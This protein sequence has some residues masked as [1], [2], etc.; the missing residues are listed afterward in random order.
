M[1]LNVSMVHAVAAAAVVQ[2]ERNAENMAEVAQ[3][4]MEQCA[5]RGTQQPR[6]KPARSKRCESGTVSE[7]N[8]WHNCGSRDTVL[9]RWLPAALR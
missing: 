7:A 4:Y 2:V 9:A 8:R 6:P 3:A 1:H 5:V